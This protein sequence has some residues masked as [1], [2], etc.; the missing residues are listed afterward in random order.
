M[1]IILIKTMN[2]DRKLNNENFM[3][4]IAELD[5]CLT[6]ALKYLWENWYHEET[7]IVVCALKD[8]DKVA[9]ATSTKNDKNWIHAENN[10]YYKFIQLF[11]QP[12][13][14]AAFIISLSPCIKKLKYRAE[15][16]CLELIKRAGISRIHFGALDTMHA[17]SISSYIYAGFATTLSKNE[18]IKT[19]CNNLMNLFQEYDSRINTELLTIKN[20]LGEG[21]F[22]AIAHE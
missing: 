16:S 17:E 7:G 9:F 22:S 19:V 4:D 3:N 20:E 14:H 10:A 18:S 1:Q 13:P 5:T 6:Q 12:S 8:G 15:P 11:G 2:L 21:F